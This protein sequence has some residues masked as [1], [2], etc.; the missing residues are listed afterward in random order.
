MPSDA[1]AV[2]LDGIH[3]ADLVRG[4]G[5]LGARLLYRDDAT[6]PLSLSLPLS[7]KEH[8]TA[9]V[10]PWLRGLLP[11][12]P[13]VIRRWADDF[14]LPDST[15]FSLLGT[16]VGHDC[17]GAVQFCDPDGIDDLLRRGGS[18]QWL[19]QR[20]LDQVVRGLHEDGTAWLGDPAWLQFSLSGGETKTSLHHDGDRWGRPTGTVPSTHILKPQLRKHDYD[21][22]PV[23]EHLCQTAA[24]HLGLPTAETDVQ[25]IGGIQTVVI[26]RYD[27]LQRDGAVVRLHQEDLCQALGIEPRRKYQV[28]GGPSVAQ[29]A[30]LLRSVSSCPSEDIAAYR[31]ALIF[32]WVIG[33]TDAHA[34][35]YSVLI[36]AD[37][38]VRLAPLYDLASGLPYVEDDNV[39]RIALAQRIGKNYT[40]RKSDR[41]SAW[42]STADALGLDRAETVERAQQIAAAAPEA[43]D[44]A[45]STL[46]VEFRES[47]TVTDL[48]RRLIHRK[49]T[50][51]SMSKEADG[52]P[53]RSPQ[54]TADASIRAVRC[55]QPLAGNDHCR[56]RLRFKACP[57]H[58]GS[59]G[60]RKALEQASAAA[61][62]ARSAAIRAAEASQPPTAPD[63]SDPAMPHAGTGV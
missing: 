10:E 43:F 22:L 59:P 62:S 13:R 14:D 33:G 36:G 40:L 58:P 39:P 11:D 35:N 34:K 7:R 18:V 52:S 26:K 48:R 51:T 2:L 8:R 38:D 60:S 5:R 45:A 41:R 42:E 31:D 50:C 17:A 56:R 46:P 9:A 53:A 54:R 32:N 12:D 27:R 21:D 57:D 63:S 1:L 47:R 29:V 30:K 6:R 25:Q 37:G 61:Q 15:S 20:E 44:L 55:G 28:K 4:R 24:R 23:N 3:V 16:A 49:R 19:S